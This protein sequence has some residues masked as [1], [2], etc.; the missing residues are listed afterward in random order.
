ME[1]FH[2]KRSVAGFT[3]KRKVQIDLSKTKITLAYDFKLMIVIIYTNFEN[4]LNSN[5]LIL[6]AVL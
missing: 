2:E 4:L 5:Q 1:V 3:T 6:N